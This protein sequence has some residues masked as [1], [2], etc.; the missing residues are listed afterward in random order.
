MEGFLNQE[1]P[2]LIIASASDSIDL[3]QRSKNGLKQLIKIFGARKDCLKVKVSV[4]KGKP[5]EG[6]CGIFVRIKIML[7]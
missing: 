5:D 2:I 7:P 6:L 3:L 4:R 1:S